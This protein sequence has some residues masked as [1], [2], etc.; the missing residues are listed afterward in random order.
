MNVERRVPDIEIERL[1]LGEL[2]PEREEEVR[3]LLEEESGGMAR[4]DVLLTSNEEILAE[5]PPHQMAVQIQERAAQSDK[6]APAKIRAWFALP[7]IASAAAAFAL[8]WML[9]PTVN[10]N[11]PEVI[12]L[13]GPT[14][15][16]LFVFRKS[17]GEEERLKEGAR[18][19]AGDILQLKY[20]ARGAAHG[21]IFSIDGR[22]GVTLHF[23]GAPDKSTALRK[24]KARAL[25]F[26]YELDDA[27]GF[28]R[29]FFITSSDPLDVNG[30]LTAGRS[31]GTN[32]TAPLILPESLA[33]NDFLLKKE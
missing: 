11:S 1:A 17:T 15:P 24:G 22:G 9:L 26:S 18:V 6:T 8:V 7:A 33:Q 27:P 20:A 3:G 5:Y 30:V 2:S 29:F 31:L 32:E 25:S 14:D 28:E 12:I 10:P 19:K 16:A 21:V 4:L 13:K 23:P